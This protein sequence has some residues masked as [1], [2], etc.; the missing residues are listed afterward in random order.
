MITDWLKIPS[1]TFLWPEA[2]YL[3]VMGIICLETAL[4]SAAAFDLGVLGAIGISTAK[5]RL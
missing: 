2:N 1:T 3:Y 5:R 4:P